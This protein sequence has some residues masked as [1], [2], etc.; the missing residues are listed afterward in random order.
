[1]ELANGNLNL[2]EAINSE[3]TFISKRNILKK[4]GN[5]LISA[6]AELVPHEQMLSSEEAGVAWLEDNQFQASRWKWLFYFY[7]LF[8]SCVGKG[9]LIGGFIA[10]SSTGPLRGVQEK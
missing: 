5:I 1:M 3:F 4:R 8:Y 2:I 9:N 6:Y 7:F 10:F